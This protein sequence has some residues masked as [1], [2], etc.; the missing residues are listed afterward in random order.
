[1]KRIFFKEAKFK[2]WMTAIIAVSF[3]LIFI[4]L[5]GSFELFG[6]QYYKFCRIVFA[7]GAL[8]QAAFLSRIFWFKNYVEWNKR[9]ISI[10]LNNFLMETIAFEK[11]STVVVDDAAKTLK[12]LLNSGREKVFKTDNII[13]NDLKILVTILKRLK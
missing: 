6:L 2:S 1:M 8:L 12:I 7:G 11:I 10:K 4:G 3:A 9:N 13:Q 5:L